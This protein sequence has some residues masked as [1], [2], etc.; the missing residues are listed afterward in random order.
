MDAKKWATA[1]RMPPRRQGGRPVVEG[2]LIGRCDEVAEWIAAAMWAVAEV[3][4]RPVELLHG[5]HQP[6]QLLF[7]VADDVLVVHHST[8]KSPLNH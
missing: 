8:A 5:Q 6:G 1:R 3:D 2:W 4:P 7:D